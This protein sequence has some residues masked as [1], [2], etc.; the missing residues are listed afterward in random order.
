ME[1]LKTKV[2]NLSSSVKD[3]L[4]TSYKLT[5]LNATDKAT[6][7][8]ASTLAAF[9]ILFLGIFVLFFLGIALG[10]WFGRMLEN[11]VAGFLLVAAVYLLII[12]VLVVLRKRIVFPMI[13]NL[14]IRKLYE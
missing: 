11:P 2:E 5:V 3:Y 12:I 6:G 9:S 1:Q 10:V 13:R 8:A 14:I 7:I 4:E